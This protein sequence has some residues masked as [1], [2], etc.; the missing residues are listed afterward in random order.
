MHLGMCQFDYL[1]KYAYFAPKM[2]EKPMFLYI[3]QITPHAFL[4]VKMTSLSAKEK[5]FKYLQFSR[6][7]NSEPKSKF[8]KKKF[9]FSIKN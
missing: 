6:L 2:S 4:H 5:K 7:Q 3:L 1:D 8:I 9:F